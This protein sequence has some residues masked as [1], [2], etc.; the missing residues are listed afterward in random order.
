MKCRTHLLRSKCSRWKYNA[1]ILRGELSHEFLRQ[2]PSCCPHWRGTICANAQTHCLI[3]IAFAKEIINYVRN[4]FSRRA[5]CTLA[6]VCKTEYFLISSF[7]GNLTKA[8]WDSSLISVDLSSWRVKQPAT[9]IRC[10]TWFTIMLWM[11]RY[12]HPPCCQYGWQ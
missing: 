11:I 10:T 6:T 2:V 1:S 3:N 12:C 4:G 8:R 7:V 5:T 9:F